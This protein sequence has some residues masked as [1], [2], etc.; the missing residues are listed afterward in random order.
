MKNSKTKTIAMNWTGVE[1]R[2]F[3]FLL[4][5]AFLLLSGYLYFVQ[6]SVF[7]IVTRGQAERQIGQL[8]TKVASLEADYMDIAGRQINADNARSLGF[9]DV[10]N[11]QNF[12]VKAKRNLSL[13]LSAN[14]I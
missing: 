14:E 4:V 10:S 12:A 5:A 7:N 11:V 6:R 2:L 13:S 8:E 1:Q 3:Y 9:R